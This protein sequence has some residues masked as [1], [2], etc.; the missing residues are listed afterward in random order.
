MVFELIEFAIL[1]IAIYGSA[2]EWVRVKDAKSHNKWDFYVPAGFL[3]LVI[4]IMFS[5]GSVN[6]SEVLSVSSVVCGVAAVPLLISLLL[7][8]SRQD[9]QLAA[10]DPLY[11]EGERWWLLAEMQP[12]RDSFSRFLGDELNGWSLEKEARRG[13]GGEITKV[14][15]DRTVTLK[16]DDGVEFDFPFE[17]LTHEDPL[18]VEEVEEKKGWWT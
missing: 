4:F 5:T 3:I 16:F 15:H 8:G 17:S 6:G 9:A 1:I 12:F 14:F 11:I 2:F 18:K 13:S 10:G 7:T